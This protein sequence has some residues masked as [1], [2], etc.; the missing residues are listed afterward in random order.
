MI[1]LCAAG[2]LQAASLTALSAIDVKLDHPAALQVLEH[3][4]DEL[5]RGS[6]LRSQD[7]GL[8][9]SAPADFFQQP[10]QHV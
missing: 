9:G 2:F 6:Q 7:P 1:I 8:Q 3:G 4:L 5:G 10:F